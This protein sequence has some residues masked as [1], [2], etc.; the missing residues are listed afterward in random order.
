MYIE[1]HKRVPHC[2]VRNPALTFSHETQRAFDRTCTKASLSLL[3]LLLFAHEPDSSDPWG[4]GKRRSGETAVVYRKTSNKNEERSK[5]GKY[6]V[7]EKINTN[8]RKNPNKTRAMQ[9]Q[10]I[11]IWAVSFRRHT[12]RE[13]NSIR[14]LPSFPDSSGRSRERFAL[15]HYFCQRLSLGHSIESSPL[16]LDS[17]LPFR[18]LAGWERVVWRHERSFVVCAE[19]SRHGR[20]HHRTARTC[21]K[22]GG[23]VDVGRQRGGGDIRVNYGTVK[24]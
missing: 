9:K 10:K 16:P 20:V 11:P 1:H 2:T 14:N 4:Q 5:T 3:L 7:T 6:E 21:K 18:D 23:G 22:T 15:F 12:E 13:P 24:T 8:T 17:V 19:R